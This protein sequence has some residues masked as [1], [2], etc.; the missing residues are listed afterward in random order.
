M[1]MD[2]QELIELRDLKEKLL[3]R[4]HDL[5]EK[6][7]NNE[8][9]PRKFPTFDKLASNIIKDVRTTENA[10]HKH[11]K[12]KF[13]KVTRQVSGIKFENID[14]KWMN[15]NIFKYTADVVTS[16]LEFFV[17]LTVEIKGEKDFEIQ[18]ITC[19]FINLDDCYMLEIKSWVQAICRKKNFSLLTSA[20]SQYS[21]AFKDRKSI[22]EQLKE[23]NYG[24]WK[25]CAE[26]DGGVTLFLHSSK[27][28][29]EHH[30]YVVFQWSLKFLEMSGKSE[31]CFNIQPTSEGTDFVKQN[32]EL[33]RKFCKKCIT[34][35]ELID[36]WHNIC[37]A[38][39]L[40]ENK[41]ESDS[42]EASMD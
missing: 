7:K 17:E 28:I 15:D 25:Q 39:D 10:L 2:N 37:N 26:E 19:H 32:Y 22:L 30:V 20:V 9:N 21:E 6:L 1:I 4:I 16:A 12:R 34:V 38:I 36:L 31:H 13:C 33:L 27:N 5:C 40:Y 24:T 29:K 23:R 11:E 14:R 8:G 41:S 35:K 3:D 42:H 18:D